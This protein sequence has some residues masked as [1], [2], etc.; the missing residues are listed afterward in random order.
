MVLLDAGCEY[1]SVSLSF[2]FMPLADTRF[3]I[4]AIHQTLVRFTI[5]SSN[6][7]HL[8]ILLHFSPHIPNHRHIHPST[9]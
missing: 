2:A 3:C 6:H 5:P 1:K 7:V 4:A 9:S 8:L